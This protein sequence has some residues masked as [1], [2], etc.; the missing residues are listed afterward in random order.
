MVSIYLFIYGCPARPT[1]IAAYSHTGMY[2]TVH[3]MNELDK[4]YVQCPRKSTVKKKVHNNK[5][6][7]FPA[8]LNAHTHRLIC[9][10]GKLHIFH[11]TIVIQTVD[12]TVLCF[13]RNWKIALSI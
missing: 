12:T 1:Q 13:A 3:H 4:S 5:H 2:F 8:V 10:N 9:A 7:L 11:T 6:V